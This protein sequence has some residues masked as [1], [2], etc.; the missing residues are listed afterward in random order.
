MGIISEEGILEETTGRMV[1]QIRLSYVVVKADVDEEREGRPRRN[2]RLRQRRLPA[3][4]IRI[5]SLHASPSGSSH[6]T[7]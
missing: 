6:V 4:L 3:A 5:A 2:E 7:Y 1:R